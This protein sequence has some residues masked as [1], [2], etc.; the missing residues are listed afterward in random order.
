MMF[1]FAEYTTFNYRLAVETSYSDKVFSRL[2]RI[3][4]MVILGEDTRN[5][6]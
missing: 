6:H 1:V 3:N 2:L 5:T 4:D